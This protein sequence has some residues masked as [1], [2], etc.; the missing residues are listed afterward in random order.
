MITI[1]LRRRGRKGLALYDIVVTNKRSA[2]DGKCI[3]KLGTYNPMTSP[4]EVRINEEKVVK[5]LGHG[6]DVSDTARSILSHAGIMLKWHMDKCVHKG[7]ATEEK[8]QDVIAKW[9]ANRNNKKNQKFSY[10]FI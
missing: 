2:R 8:R 7:T 4:S 3:E 10:T 1:R 6:A 5:W 9:E